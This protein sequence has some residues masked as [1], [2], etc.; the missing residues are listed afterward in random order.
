MSM[1]DMRHVRVR[2]TLYVQYL[3]S[4]RSDM[5]SLYVLYSVP[6]DIYIMDGACANVT[7]CRMLKVKLAKKDSQLRD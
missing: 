2:G 4:F 1:L 6:I 7:G 3:G 5:M